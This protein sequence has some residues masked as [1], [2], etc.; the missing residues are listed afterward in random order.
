MNKID[1][2]SRLPIL[3]TLLVSMLIATACTT[4]PETVDKSLHIYFVDVEGGQATLAILPTGETLLFDAGYP[5][6]G[7]SDPTP[8]N[9]RSAR[10]AQRIAAAAKDANISRID[11]LLISHFH[12]DHFG[13]VME[14]AQLMPIGTIIDHGTEVQKSRGKQKRLNLIQAYEETRAQSDY[15]K[16]TVGDLLPLK[17]AEIT[18]VSSAGSILE[19][20][21]ENVGS[22]GSFCDRPVLTPS[23][24]LENP[25]STGI[26]LR[27]GEFRFLNLG[28]LVGQPLSDLACPTNRIGT[29]D[30][31]LV[32]HH[33]GADAADPATLAAF[34]PRVA[35][36]NNGA[37]KGGSA[38]IFSVLRSAEGLE[39]V[40]QLHLSEVEGA[41]N[42]LPEQIAN[43]DTQTENWIKLS[44]KADGSFLVINGRTGERRHYDAR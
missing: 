11:F 33:G 7:K 32:P 43:L 3:A 35:I 12:E 5:G 2:H 27:Y 44:A 29:V 30:V 4:V 21:V 10:D 16:P 38:P 22:I 25:R 39:D 17:G 13:G 9:V 37:T 1:P 14:L 36:L 31:Y 19:A 26:L 20:P 8:G 40:W 34:Q 28:D 41:E 24:K 15:I 42:F 6:K 23:E 18:V